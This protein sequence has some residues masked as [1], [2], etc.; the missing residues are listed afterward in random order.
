MEIDGE[1]VEGDTPGSMV[2]LS[3][4]D[5]FY[6]GGTPSGISRRD[7]VEPFR[8]CMKSVKIESD[9]IDL[10]SSVASKGV[11]NTCAMGTLSTISLLSERSSAIFRN[12]SATGSAVQVTL[13]FKTRQP[14]GTLF[15]IG[16]DEEET[17]TLKLQDDKL[18]AQAGD[19]KVSVD[20]PSAA[21]EQ[22]HYVSVIKQKDFMR[23]DVDDLFSNEMA[24]KNG[25]EAVDSILISILVKSWKDSLGRRIHNQCVVRQARY[26]LLRWM[27]RRCHLQRKTP[28]FCKGS[29]IFGMGKR[30][31]YSS[32]L[33]AEHKEVSLSGCGLSDDT[34]VTTEKPTEASEGSTEET[35]GGRG[36]GKPDPDAKPLPTEA[37]IVVAFSSENDFQ[38]ISK[39]S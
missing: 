33:Q 22:W 1:V 23:V 4:G 36:N 35:T 2:D 11:R 24:R 3:V 26:R 39:F 32:K 16:T 6:V 13:K 9:E 38:H 12:V 34:V 20:V 30:L 15:T 28:R 10:H 18:I 8:G 27:S 19:D 17:F 7:V 31:F 21:D 5:V 29:I 37:P 14:K 25:D